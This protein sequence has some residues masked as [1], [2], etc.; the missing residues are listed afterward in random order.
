MDGQ[1]VLVQMEKRRD[2][3]IREAKQRARDWRSTLASG[4]GRRVLSEIV[5]GVCGAM[6]SPEPGQSDFQNGMRAAGLRIFEIA[7][8]FNAEACVGMFQESVNGGD[9]GE[10]RD[11]D[12]RNE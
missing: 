7:G 1:D 6:T 9:R 10:D 3:Q 8:G 11:D 5:F 4:A 12:D 2:I